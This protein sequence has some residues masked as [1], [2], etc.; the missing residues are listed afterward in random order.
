MRW[1]YVLQCEDGYFYVGETSRLYR[2]FWE[3]QD[4][5]GGLNT[6]VFM[7]EQIVAIYKVDTICKFIDYNNYVNKIID[8]ICHDSYKGFKLRDFDD[9]CEEYQHDKLEAENNITECLMIHNKETWDKIR[10]GKYTRFDI[11]YSFP[12][13]DYIKQLPLCKCGLPC[14]IR[15]NEDK[16]YLFFRCA[17]K[18]MWNKLKEDFEIDE[19]PCNF[20]MEYTKDKQLKLNENKRYEDR[21]K[22]INDL[23]KKSYWLKNVELNDDTYPHQCIGGCGRTSTSIKLSWSSEKRNLCFDCFIDKN[24]ELAK[25]YNQYIPVGKCLIKL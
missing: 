14:D 12:D 24:E 15:K 4:G 13:N 22:T 1:V 3:H 20:F 10:G 6:S 5:L 7:P 21:K 25:K 16:N 11:E 23:F 19:E 2:R 17:K 9:M 8:G 18:N